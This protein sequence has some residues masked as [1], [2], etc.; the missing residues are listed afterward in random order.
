MNQQSFVVAT[1]AL[2]VSG[3]AAHADEFQQRGTHVHGKVTVNIVVAANRLSAELDAPAINV[4]GFE[5][6]PKDAT[7]KKIVADATAWLKSGRNVL[8]VPAAAACKLAATD[9]TV[10]E[11]EAARD[12]D[13]GHAH[14]EGKSK[15]GESHADFRARLQYD[16]RNPGAL[17]VIE[18]WLLKRLPG[19]TEA[20]VNIV[21][22]NLQ[23]STVVTPAAMRVKLR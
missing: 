5:R 1:A 3:A 9:V 4:V 19:T 2:L 12:H 7:E 8:G 6:A 15:D 20:T 21:A 18:L 16:C 23:S 10:P 13:H 17:S 22:D 14:G 11:W